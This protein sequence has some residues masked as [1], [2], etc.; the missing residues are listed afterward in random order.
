MARTYKLYL[1]MFLNKQRQANGVKRLNVVICAQQFR[2]GC[3][4]INL[5]L[6]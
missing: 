2:F 5:P 6:L 3:V 1:K 4:Q